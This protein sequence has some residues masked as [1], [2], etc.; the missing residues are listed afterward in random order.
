MLYT[1]NTGILSHTIY[2]ILIPVIQTAL[3]KDRISC[4]SG[5][6]QGSVRSCGTPHLGREEKLL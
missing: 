3:A 1:T 5:Y 6:V 4:T 2:T